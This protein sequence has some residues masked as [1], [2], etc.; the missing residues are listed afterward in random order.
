LILL[1]FFENF[2]RTL[3]LFSN[4]NRKRRKFRMKKALAV[5]F[6][7][8]ISAAYA[9]SSYRVN[10]VK[11]TTVNGTTLNPGDC[12]IELA[13]DKVVIKQGKT[14][15]EANVTVQNAPQKFVLTTVGYGEGSSIELHDL[16]LAGTTL[17]L[18]FEG[19]K[20]EGAVAGK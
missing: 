3:E 20:P 9:A 5:L 2:P 13:G 14:T 7:L 12:K 4:L 1:L 11:T 6:A 17:K 16:H 15:V 8:S 18:T 19:S 10:L